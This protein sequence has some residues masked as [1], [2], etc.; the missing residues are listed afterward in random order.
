MWKPFLLKKGCDESAFADFYALAN[1][2]EWGMQAA[3]GII[4]KIVKKESG[5]YPVNNVSGFIVR[6]VLERWDS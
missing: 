1:A 3:M 6:A 4:H 5:Y 2:G